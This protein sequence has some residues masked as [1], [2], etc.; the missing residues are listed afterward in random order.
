MAYFG[1]VYVWYDRLKQKLY[2]GSHYGS[3][4][5][6]LRKGGYVC[7]SRYMKAAYKGR[8]SHFMRRV[9]YWQT[10]PDRKELLET[11]QRWLDLIPKGELGKRFYNLAKQAKNHWHVDEGK[12]KR[13]AEDSRPENR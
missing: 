7:S 9:V 10:T 12:R 5:I 11:E 6:S 4:R 8:P 13:K 3:S 1:F 2:I